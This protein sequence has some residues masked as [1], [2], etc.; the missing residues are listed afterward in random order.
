LLGGQGEAR[1]R[2]G[3][4]RYGSGRPELAKSHVWS[5]PFACDSFARAVAQRVGAGR[6]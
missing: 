5:R 1:G 6:L 3:G 2:A 4:D